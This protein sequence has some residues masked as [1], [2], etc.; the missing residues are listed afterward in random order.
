V[1]IYL[2]S[3]PSPVFLNSVD[4]EIFNIFA[5]QTRQP[6]MFAVIIEY[7]MTKEA[8]SSIDIPDLF[9]ADVDSNLRGNTILN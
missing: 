6:V 8:G 4:R 3:F 1:A 7:V 2:Y 9:A 5:V